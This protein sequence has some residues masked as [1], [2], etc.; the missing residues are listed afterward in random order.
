MSRPDE[1]TAHQRAAHEIPEHLT[2]HD[3]RHSPGPE[4]SKQISQ[5]A[6]LLVGELEAMNATL[7]VLVG[8]LTRDR[9]FNPAA[10]AAGRTG[11]APTICDRDL[12][13][14]AQQR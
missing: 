3:G 1:L 12:K 10:S 7:A 14:E 2:I 4:G 11:T 8:I 5:Q 9:L 6:R 13:S